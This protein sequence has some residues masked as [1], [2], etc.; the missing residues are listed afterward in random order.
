MYI[1]LLM[2]LV[3]Y[4]LDIIIKP[5]NSLDMKKIIAPIFILALFLAFSCGEKNTKNNTTENA[6]EI[7]EIEKETQEIKNLDE[8]INEEIKEIEDLLKDI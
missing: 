7:M 1:Y 2:C 5:F 8:K 6:Q 4:K 3:A